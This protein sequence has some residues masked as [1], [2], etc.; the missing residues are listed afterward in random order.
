MFQALSHHWYGGVTTM[1]E[2]EVAPASIIR[3]WASRLFRMSTK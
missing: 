2:I 1:G 3:D